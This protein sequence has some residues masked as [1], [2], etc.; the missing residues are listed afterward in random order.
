[1]TSNLYEVGDSYCINRPFR[2]ISAISPSRVRKVLGQGELGPDKKCSNLVICLVEVFA[3]HHA[4][5]PVLLGVSWRKI[6]EASNTKSKCFLSGEVLVV[7][8]DCS[9]SVYMSQSGHAEAE[10]MPPA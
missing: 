2:V 8:C 1:M 10:T 9:I 4:V 7:R 6:H 5:L 3:C